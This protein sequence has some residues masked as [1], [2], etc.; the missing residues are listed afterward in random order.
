[1]EQPTT[2]TGVL[3]LNP[4]TKSQIASFCKQVVESIDDGN[5]SALDV[6]VKCRAMEKL[7][8]ELLP[9]IKDKILKEAELYPEK[10]FEFQGNALEK[11]EGGVKYNFAHCNDSVWGRLKADAETAADRLK[12]RETL[13]RALKEPT[14][15]VDELTGEVVKVMPPA[16]TSTSVIKV[17]LK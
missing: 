14:T 8:E 7:V 15:M 4:S 3:R 10:T 1:M 2:A 5:E 6:L 16:K 17:S 9:K 11:T 12:D 13:L